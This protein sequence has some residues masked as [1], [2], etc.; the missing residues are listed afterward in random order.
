MT[1]LQLQDIDVE[2]R[3]KLSTEVLHVLTMAGL[4]GRHHTAINLMYHE[5]RH[6]LADA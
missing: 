6:V 5:D 2:T 3:R 1:C 4:H